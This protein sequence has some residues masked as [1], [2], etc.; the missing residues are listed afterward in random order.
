MNFHDFQEKKTKTADFWTQK[1]VIHEAKLGTI[2][3][4]N[5]DTIGESGIRVSQK[6]RYFE[7]IFCIFLA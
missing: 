4:H 7:K 3:V 2:S 1:T 6:V 5:V